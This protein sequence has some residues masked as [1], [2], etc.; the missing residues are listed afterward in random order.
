MAGKVVVIGGGA[1]G[2]VAAGRAAELGAEVILLEKNK[3]VGRKLLITGKGRCNVT[4]IGDINKFIAN[5]SGN[6]QFLYSAFSRFF[7]KELQELLEE[8]G[9]TLKVERGGRLFPTT[10]KAADV[11]SA[12]KKYALKHGTELRLNEKVLALGV[13]QNKVTGVETAGGFIAAT[14]VIVATGGKSYP[15]T[16]S[17]GDGYLWAE[18]AGHT[19]ITP[20]PALVPLNTK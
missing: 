15:A 8:H 19:V 10:D 6:G 13:E 3:M 2:L 11:V 5:Y 1:A 16:G 4:N 9:L 7:N 14:C 20:R 12:L 18:K 17:T